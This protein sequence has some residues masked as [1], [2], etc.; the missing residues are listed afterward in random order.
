MR[1][2]LLRS[3]APAGCQPFRSGALQP[4]LL[5]CG[6]RC[7]SVPSRWLSVA[8][9][10]WHSIARAPPPLSPLGGGARCT[11]AAVGMFRRPSADA[12]RSSA[13]APLLQ[14]PLP[15]RPPPRPLALRRTLPAA[16][17][18]TP[19][20]LGVLPLGRLTALRF[21]Q[22]PVPQRFAVV[23]SLQHRCALT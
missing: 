11:N 17:P 21:A 13:L 19:F 7:S 9:P 10:P 5:C 22:R 1:G 20:S 4:L 8:S 12:Q 15:L 23:C 3:A 18:P 6:V 14:R 2:G 16:L